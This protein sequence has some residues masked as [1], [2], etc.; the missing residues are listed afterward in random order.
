MNPHTNQLPTRVIIREVGLRDGLQSIATIVSTQ[1]KCEWLRDAVA[2]GQTE[3]EVGSFVPPKLLPQ[4]ADTEQVLAYAKTLPGLSA[5]VLVPNL[6]GA[7]SALDGN[8]DLMILPLSASH[9]HSMANLRKTPDDVVAELGRIRAARD[10]SGKKTLIEGGVGTAFGC[11]IQGNV[12]ESEVL[13]LMQ[14]LLDAGADRV[15]LADTVGYADPASVSRLFEKALKIAGERFWSG[16]FHDTRGLALVNVHAALQ[17]GVHRFDTSLAGIGGCPHA[18]GAS[19]N[20][21]T[22]DLAFML[23]AMGIDTGL[24]ISAL[25]ALRSKVASWIEGEPTHGAL[26]RAGLPKTY[27]NAVAA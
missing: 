16:H 25:L 23:G 11:T 6:R 18:P 9:A 17:L 21:S 8:A 5:S 7:E 2:A 19:G 1:Q 4:L 27:A 20:A 13:R 12:D 24:D 15:S 3:I 26:W 22:E 10:A 14:A